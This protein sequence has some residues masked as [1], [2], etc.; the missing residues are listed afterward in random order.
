MP[1]RFGV[2]ALKENAGVLLWT[3]AFFYLKRTKLLNV[4]QSAHTVH[5]LIRFYKMGG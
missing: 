4:Y 2:A 1:F 3:P 5:V